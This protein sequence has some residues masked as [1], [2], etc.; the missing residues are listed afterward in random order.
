MWTISFRSIFFKG[1]LHINRLADHHCKIWVWVFFY[2]FTICYFSMIFF[3]CSRWILKRL[4]CANLN[5]M[6]FF[7]TKIMLTLKGEKKKIRRKRHTEHD[8]YHQKINLKKKLLLNRRVIKLINF[9]L[10]QHSDSG[11][12]TVCSGCLT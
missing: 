8:V 11:S 12:I 9:L 5:K 3:L 10:K 4:F 7:A 1:Y 6:K 2:V